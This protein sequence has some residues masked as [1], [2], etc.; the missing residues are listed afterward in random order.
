MSKVSSYY[1]ASK[2]RNRKMSNQ[3]GFFLSRKRGTNNN[4]CNKCDDC[5]DCD[6]Y[7][8]NMESSCDCNDNNIDSLSQS[9]DLAIDNLNGSLNNTIETKTMSNNSKSNNNKKTHNKKHHNKNKRKNRKCKGPIYVP[10]Y[11]PKSIYHPN[12]TC[13]KLTG[14][15]PN[16]QS[17]TERSCGGIGIGDYCPGV[18]ENQGLTSYLPYEAM[19]GGC[20]N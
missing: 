8:C 9:I 12:N 15:S 10:E 20:L 2:L 7:P 19:N 11:D 5:D 3:R 14:P 18:G 17:T 6:D 4:N 13:Q 16:S 1:L